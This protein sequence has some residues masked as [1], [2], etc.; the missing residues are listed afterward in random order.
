MAHLGKNFVVQDST[1]AKSR[2]VIKKSLFGA[3]IRETEF[4]IYHFSLFTFNSYAIVRNESPCWS[5]P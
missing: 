3:L 4:V 5:Q 1:H 2:R